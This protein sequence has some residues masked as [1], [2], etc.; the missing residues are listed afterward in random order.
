[1]EADLILVDP[2]A[3]W[4]VDGDR[5][6]ALAGN[7]PFDRLPVQGRVRHMLKGGKII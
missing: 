6:A 5:M 2:D 4:Q 3:P 1:Y 7:T